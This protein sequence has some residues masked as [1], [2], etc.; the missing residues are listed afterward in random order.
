MCLR[1]N[2]ATVG[3]LAKILLAFYR[4]KL[5]RLERSDSIRNLTLS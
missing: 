3:E 1:L 4:K 2:V 5:V